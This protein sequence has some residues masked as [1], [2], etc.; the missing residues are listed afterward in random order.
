MCTQDIAI[1]FNLTLTKTLPAYRGGHYSR[2]QR[3][4]Y[5]LNQSSWHVALLIASWSQSYIKEHEHG[6]MLYIT[7]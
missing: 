6:L 1:A 5:E 3:I 2:H 4:S 7:I